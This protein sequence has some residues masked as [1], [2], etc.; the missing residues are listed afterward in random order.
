MLP[1]V[2]CEKLGNCSGL[3]TFIG[4]MNVDLTNFLFFYFFLVRGHKKNSGDLPAITNGGR[5]ITSKLFQI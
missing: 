3:V 4:E 2:M 1:P 5:C